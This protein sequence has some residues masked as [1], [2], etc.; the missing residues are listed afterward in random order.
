MTL[1]RFVQR[2][3]ILAGITFVG[4]AFL[5]SSAT[6]QTD[7]FCV[8]ASNGKTVVGRSKLLSGLV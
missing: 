2:A 4:I 3:S 1:I 5:G 6:A 8:V 7:K